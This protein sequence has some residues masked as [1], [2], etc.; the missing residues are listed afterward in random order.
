MARVPVRQAGGADGQ[1]RGAG[2]P[3]QDE[4]TGAP[5]ACRSWHGRAGRGW[6]GLPCSFD[7]APRRACGGARAPL[8]MTPSH[9][10]VTAITWHCGRRR[11]ALRGSC[12]AAPASRRRPTPGPLVRDPRGTWLRRRFFYRAG[13]DPA[14]SKFGRE[15][16][17]M[18][19]ALACRTGDDVSRSSLCCIGSPGKATRGR[20]AATCE[21]GFGA[22][23]HGV[24]REHEHPP[25]PRG[26]YW[27]GRRRG[28]AWIA[29]ASM[30]SG[31]LT[32]RPAG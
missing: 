16:R 8:G 28:V 9:D 30:P 20:D 14:L 32:R 3:A 21:T 5:R 31:S 25:A 6:Q 1:G 13:P 27:H 24:S 26:A 18:E 29:S 4:C 22:S 10:G 23:E 7:R 17:F 11:A 19:I 15:A 2:C 12:A